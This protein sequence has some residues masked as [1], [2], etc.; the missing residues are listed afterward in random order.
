MNGFLKS[1][2]K[3]WLRYGAL[4]T[5]SWLYYLPAYGLREVSYTFESQFPHWKE[6]EIAERVNWTVSIPS[7]IQ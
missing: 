7:F 5:Q 6:T 1:Q 3:S 2:L 4:V